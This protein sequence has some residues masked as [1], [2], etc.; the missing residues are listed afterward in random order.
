MLRSVVHDLIIIA[1]SAVVGAVIAAI[2]LW[3]GYAI[4][5][6]KL[7]LP[8]LQADLERFNDLPAVNLFEN[9]SMA[10]IPH[11]RMI[12]RMQEFERMEAAAE[13]TP[14]MLVHTGWNIVCEAFIRRFQAYPDDTRIREA[15]STIGGQNV[16]FVTM[17]RDILS[18]AMQHPAAV[19]K[20]FAAN[21]L[22]RAPSLAERVEGRP[23]VMSADANDQLALAAGI[24]S[25]SG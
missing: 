12:E 4:R 1:L 24:V 8:F 18:A 17:Y 23:P 13:I 3:R 9:V 10:S 5:P 6:T 22:V 20:R 21:Y 19:S 15:A 16:E 11:D 14:I 25:H 7:T 2:A